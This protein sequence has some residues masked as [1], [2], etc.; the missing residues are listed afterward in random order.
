MRALAQN[1]QSILNGLML[2]I[3]LI[4]LICQALSKQTR[5]LLILGFF[6]CKLEIPPRNLFQ[7]TLHGKIGGYR[8]MQI[9]YTVP[10]KQTGDLAN[11]CCSL[12]ANGK[13]LPGFIHKQIKFLCCMITHGTS[14]TKLN[15]G[16]RCAKN[17]NL[18][19][20]VRNVV[21]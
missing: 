3:L 6:D 21:P 18:F 9:R 5:D 15:K 13:F 11:T 2:L 14:G 10:Q 7:H 4:P 19:F 1:R 16:Q 17:M 20:L 8:C 12:P